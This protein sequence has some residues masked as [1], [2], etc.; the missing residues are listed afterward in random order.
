ML[1]WMLSMNVLFW[2]FVACDVGCDFVWQSLKSPGSDDVTCCCN[3]AYVSTNVDVI[4]LCVCGNVDLVI[5]NLWLMLCDINDGC[6]LAV[7]VPDIVTSEC[8]GFHD[9]HC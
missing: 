2:S 7:V 4:W 8:I 6:R 5:P 3:Y 9:S 1:L